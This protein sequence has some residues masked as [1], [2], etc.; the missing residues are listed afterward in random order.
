MFCYIVVEAARASP[1]IAASNEASGGARAAATER[2]TTSERVT[3][4]IVGAA[5]LARVATNLALAE[6]LAS[7]MRSHAALTTP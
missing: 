1:K 2:F 5:E 6:F 4:M 3:R 7:P